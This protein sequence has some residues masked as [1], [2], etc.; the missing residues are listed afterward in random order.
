MRLSNVIRK[1]N[2]KMSFIFSFFFLSQRRNFMA[3]LKRGIWVKSH[4]MMQFSCPYGFSNLLML[5]ITKE[6]LRV[7]YINK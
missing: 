6:V 2:D 5:H 3:N 4:E 1:V 7:I